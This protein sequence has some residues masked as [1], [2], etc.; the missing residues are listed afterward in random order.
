MLSFQDFHC[1]VNTNS[2]LQYFTN[3]ETN[4]STLDETEMLFFSS[5]IMGD[6]FKVLHS[7]SSENIVYPFK[8]QVSH[9]TSNEAKPTHLKFSIFLQKHV[10]LYLGP[11]QQIHPYK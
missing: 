11:L 8:V 1:D 6:D 3:E 2:A 5:E 10:L 9:A 4:V 7:I